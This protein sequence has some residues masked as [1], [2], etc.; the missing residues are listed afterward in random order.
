MK[1]AEKKEGENAMT[2]NKQS[3]DSTTTGSEV[4]YKNGQLNR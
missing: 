2:T 4:P 1:D 3:Q